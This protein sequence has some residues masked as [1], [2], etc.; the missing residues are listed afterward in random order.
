ML[1]WPTCSSGGSSSQSSLTESYQQWTSCA[2]CKGSTN[3][4]GKR[5]CFDHQ[6]ETYSEKSD[7]LCPTCWN[8][9]RGHKTAT[10][11]GFEDAE[12]DAYSEK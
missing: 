8:A 10:T 9:D 11:D 3:G 5:W 4:K 6:D 1:L 12:D 2:F 7:W